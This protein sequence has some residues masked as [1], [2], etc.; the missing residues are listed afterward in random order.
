MKFVQYKILP[1]SPNMLFFQN[2]QISYLY[3]L[4]LAEIVCFDKQIRDECK[5]CMYECTEM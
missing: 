3:R 5:I 2:V 1:I 4:G